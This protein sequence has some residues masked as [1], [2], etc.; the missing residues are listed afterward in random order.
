MRCACGRRATGH[1]LLRDGNGRWLSWCCATVGMKALLG[2]LIADGTAIPRRDPETVVGIDPLG[3]FPGIPP[4]VVL[5]VQ[6][7]TQT[8]TQNPRPTDAHEVPEPDPDD[9][10]PLFQSRL[11]PTGTLDDTKRP[12]TFHAPEPAYGTSAVLR[13]MAYVRAGKTET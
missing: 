2:K 8:L 4:S 1:V 9:G 12:E 3:R 6:G 13:G 5:G 11:G 7:V 10:K